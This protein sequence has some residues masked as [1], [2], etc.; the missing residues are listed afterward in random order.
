MLLHEK[1]KHTKF[2]AAETQVVN[3]LLTQPMTIEELTIK[4]IAQATFVNDSTLIR[5]AKKLDFTGWIELK[6]AFLAEYRYLHTHFD[7][8]DANL[9]FQHTDGL[10]TIANKMALLE[11]TT[12][13]DTLSLLNHEKLKQARAFLL[14]AKAIKIFGSN[15]NTLIAQD[16]A[17]KMRRINQNVVI[18]DTYGEHAYEAHNCQSD[19]CTILI[20]YTGENP[21]ILQ[22]A[23]I[24]KQRSV[25]II[26][27]TS[28]GDNSL[29][30][31]ADNILQ[32]TTRERPYSK[33]GNFT[34]NTSLCYLL[35]VLYSCVFAANYQR[36]MNHLIQVGELVDRRKSSSEIMAEKQLLF[37]E[38]FRPN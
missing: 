23:N 15:A 36:N 25:P 1:M 17:L 11:K 19:E 22:T 4:E 30:T 32:I 37:P 29:A 34:T 21:M 7:Q 14:N 8:I 35:D 2:S 26:A 9:P 13:A 27:L 5:V 28:I 10:M 3:F 33:I 12:T 38:S 16:F 24:L 31:L 18:C 20:S 6:K